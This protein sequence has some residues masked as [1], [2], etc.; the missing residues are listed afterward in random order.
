MRLHNG[1][2]VSLK[3]SDYRTVPLC[4]SCHTRQHQVGER[5]FWDSVGLDTDAL[6]ASLLLRYLRDTRA[7]VLA[8]E[9]LVESER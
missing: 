1:G 4:H 5:S 8:L 6:I 3:P 2:G 7:A 9:R